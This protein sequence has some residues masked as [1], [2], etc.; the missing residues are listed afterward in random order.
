MTKNIDW[1][2]LGFVYQPTDYS[3]TAMHKDGKWGELEL[4]ADHTVQM[5]ECACVLQYAV[6]ERVAAQRPTAVG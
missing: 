4:T 5:S 2:S 3:V 6:Q 1:G